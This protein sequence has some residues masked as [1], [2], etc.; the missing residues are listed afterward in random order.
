MDTQTYTKEKREGENKRV[1][2]PLEEKKFYDSSKSSVDE[3]TSEDE[4]PKVAPY[5]LQVAKPL[6]KTMHCPLL[7]QRKQQQSKE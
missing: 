4:P 3:E 6:F 7:E 2:V 5:V 1:D